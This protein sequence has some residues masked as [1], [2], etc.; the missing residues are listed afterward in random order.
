MDVDREV[1]AGVEEADFLHEVKF[2][3]E[4]AAITAI[5]SENLLFIMYLF[6]R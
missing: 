6:F 3:I 1:G 4:N 5:A 2:S